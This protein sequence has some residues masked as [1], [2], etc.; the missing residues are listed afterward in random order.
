[1]DICKDNAHI[2]YS[3]F[4]GFTVEGI[5]DKSRPRLLSIEV[6]SLTI[7]MIWVTPFFVTMCL[8]GKSH[9]IEY[10]VVEE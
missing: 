7:L 2:K 6:P 5:V 3:L 1:M 10:Y 8:V 4:E 9:C